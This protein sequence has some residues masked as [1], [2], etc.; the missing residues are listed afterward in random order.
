MWPEWTLPHPP[1]GSTRPGRRAKE[2]VEERGELG[3]VLGPIRL[4]FPLLKHRQLR[5]GFLDFHLASL[6]MV[7][8]GGSAPDAQEDRLE[9]TVR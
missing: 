4:E 5:H 9:I 1:A 3:A 2:E 8:L 7:A 6:R